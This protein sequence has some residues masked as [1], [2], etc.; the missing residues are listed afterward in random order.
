[1]RVHAKH[2]TAAYYKSVRARRSS[3]TKIKSLVAEEFVSVPRQRQGTR[4]CGLM[5]ARQVQPGKSGES[6]PG[7]DLTCCSASPAR[8]SARPQRDCK[9]PPSSPQLRVAAG[10]YLVPGE[11]VHVQAIDR[12][13]WVQDDRHAV[14]QP[15]FVPSL[16]DGDRQRSRCAST[17]V[18]RNQRC[19]ARHG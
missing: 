2:V 3:P 16:V 18:R 4:V 6:T 19:R 17:R 14:A 9:C 15:T 12:I 13:S 10:T 11:L 7:H 1:M 5:H 8:C